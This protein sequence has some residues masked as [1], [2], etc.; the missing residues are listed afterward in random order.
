MTHQ[1]DDESRMNPRKPGLL[2]D[3]KKNRR[4]EKKETDSLTDR[5]INYR[6]GRDVSDG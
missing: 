6:D 4:R 5:H 2:P 3:M 1:S